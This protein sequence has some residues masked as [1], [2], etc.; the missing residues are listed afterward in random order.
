MGPTASGKTDL[1]IALCDAIP[2]EII[3]VDSAL[4]YKDMDIGT[5]KPEPELLKRYPHYLVDIVDPA[6]SYSVG[7]FHRDVSQYCDE[8]TARGNIPLLVGGTMMYFRAL[9]LGL[10]DLP[11]SS[12]EIRAELE[13]E[14][15]QCGWEQMHQ[16]LA[17][18]DPKSAS[19]IHR[20][21]PQRIQRALEV[22]RLTGKAMSQHH[23]EQ[24]QRALPYQAIPL[25]LCPAER[26]I[27]HQ[28]IEQ[29]FHLMMEQGFLSE[30]EKLYTRGD[31]HADLP[32]IRCVGYR[33]LWNYFTGE[34][35][36]DMA[37]AKGVVATR[38]LAKRQITW[39]RSWDGG[40]WID[41]MK[42]DI[43]EQALKFV[44]SAIHK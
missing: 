26:S 41:T 36:L 32:S 43:F 25:I 35:D 39:L 34:W 33:Q 18:V 28:R 19:Q 7:Q 27:L 30:V 14:A 17:D 31:L 10:S 12:S 4:I 3:S 20:N 1:A 8:I 44:S 2:C 37:I 40:I 42:Q 15:L 23:A 29:R 38:K 22:Y 6:D 21:D 5:A 13:Q 9:Q 24:Q 11:P 16:K